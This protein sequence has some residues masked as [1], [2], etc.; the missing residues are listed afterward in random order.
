MGGWS[1]SDTAAIV[2]SLRSPRGHGTCLMALTCSFPVRTLPTRSPLSCPTPSGKRRGK[3]CKETRMDDEAQQG[4]CSYELP[5]EMTREFVSRKA[6]ET[7]GL[8]KRTA[9]HILGIG[10]NLHEVK[11][12]LPHGQFLAWLQ[13]EFAMS[14]RQARN[15]MHVAT[16]FGTKP[17]ILA[18]LSLTVIYALAAPS[19]SQ[20]VLDQVESKQISPTLEAIRAAKEAERQAREAEQQARAEVQR[21]QQALCSLREETQAQQETI[22]QLTSDID[23]LQERIADLSIQA[24]SITE[25]EQPGASPEITTPLESLRQQVQHLTQQRDILTQ[26]VTQLGEEARAAALKRGEEEQDRRIRLH[27]FRLTTTFQASLR[28]LLAEWPSPVDTQ[29]FEADDWARL[30]QVKALARRL[31][32]ACDALTGGP[33]GMVVDS[34]TMPVG[35]GSNAEGRRARDV[36]IGR[37]V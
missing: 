11:E 37:H 20:A 36:V 1:M 27:W 30:A 28:S 14:E 9:Q 23:A 24:A 15:F 25:G 7:R 16:R 4:S 19:T 29:A 34:A 3:K 22:A 33:G 12:R 18:D 21:T 5:D 10:R 35:E 31:L 17:E 13:A 6:D 8:L 32:V 26:Q 2:M